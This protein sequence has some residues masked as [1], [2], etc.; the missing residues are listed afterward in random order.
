MGMLLRKIWGCLFVIS[1]MVITTYS[2]YATAQ[3]VYLH[4]ETGSPITHANVILYTPDSAI[5]SYYITDD[6]GKYEWELSDISDQLL[7]SIRALGCEPVVYKR[8]HELLNAKFVTDTIVLKETSYSLQETI[9]KAKPPAVYTKGDTVVYNLDQLDV[10]PRQR[11]EDYLKELDNFQVLENGTI[12]YLG[13]GIKKILLDGTDLTGASYQKIS[14]NI[15]ADMIQS[16]EVINN[17]EENSVKSR[18][19]KSGDIGLNLKLKES[20]YDLTGEITG[21]IGNPDRW[22]SQLNALYISKKFKS[23]LGGKHDRFSESFAATDIGNGIIQQDDYN[24]NRLGSPNQN[25]KNPLLQDLP[26]SYRYNDRQSELDFN[27]AFAIKAH[28]FRFVANTH[29][30]D[31]PINFNESSTF[32]FPSQQIDF[33][34]RQNNSLSAKSRTHHLGGEYKWGKKDLKYHRV[35]V[36]AIYDKSDIHQSQIVSGAFTD[37]TYHDLNTSPRGI[38]MDGEH[39]F[40]LD[41]YTAIFVN[42]EFTSKFTEQTSSAQNA[43]WE[44]GFLF[45]DNK[46][47][48]QLFDEQFNQAAMSVSYVR[49][50]R[51]LIQSHAILPKWESREMLLKGMGQEKNNPFQSTPYSHSSFTANYRYFATMNT[52][53]ALQPSLTLSGGASEAKLNG[54]SGVQLNY[55]ARFNLSYQQKLYK[56]Y[57]LSLETKR[58]LNDNLSNY[59]FTYFQGTQSLRYKLDEIRP[60]ISYRLNA[61]IYDKSFYGGYELSGNAYYVYHKNHLTTTIVEDPAN[62]LFRPFYTDLQQWMGFGKINF[63]INQWLTKVDFSLTYSGTAFDQLVNNVLSQ[64][65]SHSLRTRL[66]LRKPLG[67]QLLI[68][69]FGAPAYSVFLNDRA[70]TSTNFFFEGGGKLS[71]SPNKSLEA[72]AYYKV[73]DGEVVENPFHLFDIGID[74]KISD[75]LEVNLTCQN[76]LD[77]RSYGRIARESFYSYGRFVE[78]PGR[79]VSLEVSY[80]F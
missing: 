28:K 68:S 2:Q 54:I 73:L 53:K 1:I 58:S 40:S 65:I 71:W 39:S 43:R 79:T 19:L 22:A 67:K 30:H 41:D 55:L 36:N 25:I 14:K 70:P 76:L 47:F 27:S 11:L 3:S 26:Q 45:A 75:I 64:N 56:R 80:E 7:I 9:I 78:I 17:F 15:N 51:L 16:I 21:R 74:Y 72:T 4:S 13:N 46:G 66:E 50:G 20:A 77:Y 37:S 5:H 23:L 62:S 18:F 24:F 52:K 33:E 57:S 8:I 10:D 34:T 38:Y 32:S 31:I 12:K 42:T 63:V 48:V 69:A 35:K 59:Y 44:E 61:N 6:H 60:S 29:A 49:K